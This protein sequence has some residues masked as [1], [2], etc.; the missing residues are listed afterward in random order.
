MTKECKTFGNYESYVKLLI[1]SIKRG[2][3]YFQPEFVRMTT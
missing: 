3:I 1:T 2:S